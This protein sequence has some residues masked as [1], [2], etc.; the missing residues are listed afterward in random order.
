ML[1]EIYEVGMGEY[2]IGKDPVVLVSKG[3]GS[4]I[5][6]CLYDR[7]KRIGAMAHAMLPQA[8]KDADGD[9]ETK[10]VDKVLPILLSELD[11]LGCKKEDLVAKLVGGANMFTKLGGFSKDISEKNVKIGREMLDAEKID[12][13]GESTGGTV[14]RGVEFNLGNGVVSVISKI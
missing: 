10:Y 6:I 4:C 5:V 2:K 13:V 12:I 11:N 9:S 14:G 1:E 7:T 8:K 3:V